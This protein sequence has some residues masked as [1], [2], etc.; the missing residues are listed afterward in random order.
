MEVHHIQECGF[1]ELS[2]R[3]WGC[4]PDQRLMGKN[5]R[6]LW[7]RPKVAC[8]P[9]ILKVVKEIVGENTQSLEVGKI[10][11]AEMETLYIFDQV[12]EAGEDTI[13]PIVRDLPKKI[14]EVCPLIRLPR[15]HIP[16]HHSELI[17]VRQ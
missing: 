1:D 11:T 9:E 2:F 14:I 5:D 15:L 3:Q 6:A 7:N 13:S 17:E 12:R 10:F 4:Y 16:S 8:E